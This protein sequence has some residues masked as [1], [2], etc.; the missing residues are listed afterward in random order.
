MGRSASTFVL[1]PLPPR[2]S[3]SGARAPASKYC[4]MVT[5]SKSCTTRGWALRG[6]SFLT[7]AKKD[8]M[9][10]AGAKLE[11]R[12][13]RVQSPP[14]QSY[15]VHKAPAASPVN[16]LLRFSGRSRRHVRLAV[17]GTGVST[18]TS[19]I[20]FPQLSFFVWAP[21]PSKLTSSVREVGVRAPPHPE[22]AY[23]SSAVRSASRIARGELASGSNRN[24]LPFC[25]EKKELPLMSISMS[26]ASSPGSRLWVKDSSVQLVSGGEGQL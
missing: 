5:S 10:V 23:P 20:E 12:S 7:Y 19:T 21:L 26:L 25:V 14:F 3:S 11:A 22:V 2:V 17:P 1:K 18:V 4:V 6:S 8:S 13:I 9:G 16:W 24:S 15:W